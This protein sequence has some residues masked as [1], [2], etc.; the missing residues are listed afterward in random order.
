MTY[1]LS[2]LNFGNAVFDALIEAGVRD[3][4]A[5]ALSRAF[6]F[7]YAQAAILGFSFLVPAETAEE[8]QN[9]L[10]TVYRRDILREA[11]YVTIFSSSLVAKAE[12]TY[13]H[14]ETRNNTENLL[15]DYSNTSTNA[16][17]E[18]APV[19]VAYSSTITTPNL[20]QKGQTTNTRNYEKKNDDTINYD[21]I[22]HN[23]L[24]DLRLIK[25]HGVSWFDICD[26]IIYN[27][28]EESFEVY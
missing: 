20:L 3:M 5:D 11:K 14:N 18:N 27:W 2:E 6:E 24:E 7:S 28:T 13:T 9:I 22:E 23:P 8:A 19:G 4:Q 16:G 17:S 25:E 12:K 10:Q 15:N 26:K 21:T 1:K